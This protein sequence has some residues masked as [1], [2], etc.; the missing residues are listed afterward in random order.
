MF[1]PANCNNRLSFDAGPPHPLPICDHSALPS[2]SV[3]PPSRTMRVD[4]A[5]SM[6]APTSAVTISR[7]AEIFGED[8]KIFLIGFSAASVPH[9]L[10]SFHPT[11][12][13]VWCC[14]CRCGH[15][16]NALAL[17]IMSTALSMSA[18]VVP[19]RHTAVGIAIQVD[20][21]VFERAPQSFDEHVVHTAPAAIHGALP[22]SPSP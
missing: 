6:V 10:L 1:F 20:V 22:G 19:S 4:H 11:I 18:P 3:T 12:A 7:A 16:G 13:K 9:V 2:T 5:V 21:L 14:S 17:S 15:V 8:Q